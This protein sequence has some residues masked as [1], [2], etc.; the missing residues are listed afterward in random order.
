[1][2]CFHVKK[3]ND[4]PGH[5]FSN[6][7][8]LLRPRK[9]CIFLSRQRQE[10]IFVECHR[11]VFKCEKEKQILFTLLEGHE[12]SHLYSILLAQVFQSVVPPCQSWK[13][14]EAWHLTPNPTKANYVNKYL[15]DVEGLS[16]PL[17]F[18]M[19]GDLQKFYLVTYRSFMFVVVKLL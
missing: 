9:A 19:P 13:P 5:S 11:K 16:A 14:W 6:S 2:S 3:A 15:A 12:C 4:F 17:I 10:Q 7:F 8:I 1:M 18:F